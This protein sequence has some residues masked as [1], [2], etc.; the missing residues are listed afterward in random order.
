MNLRKNTSVGICVFYADRRAYR[1]GNTSSR[2]SVKKAPKHFPAGSKTAGFSVAS[3]L[4]AFGC[5]T[6]QKCDLPEG[7]K[8][9]SCQ[10]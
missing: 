1:H 2:Y 9:D 5:C 6:L 8:N 7:E 4:A 10:I 3:C